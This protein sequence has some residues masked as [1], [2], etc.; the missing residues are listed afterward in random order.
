MAYKYWAVR[1]ISTGF[2]LP[3]IGRRGY[4]YTIPMPLDKC[5]PRLHYHAGS[6]RR[7]KDA[8][9]RGPHMRKYSAG[10]YD[11]EPEDYVD[12]DTK[13]ARNK[14]DFEVV[15]VYFNV[16]GAET[17]LRDGRKLDANPWMTDY[18]DKGQK[19]PG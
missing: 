9:C 18:D 1:Q 3:E 12:I 6:A 5:V 2:F 8:Y 4:T 15:S 19:D 13:K 17:D 14:N 11:M 10:S 16:L 7:A